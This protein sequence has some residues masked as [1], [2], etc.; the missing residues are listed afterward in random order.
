MTA[1][2]P[3]VP[4]ALLDQLAI[5]GRLV[6]PVGST[7]PFQ[8]LVRVTRRALDDYTQDD[9]EDV[10]FVPLIGEQGWPDRDVGLG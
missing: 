8:H 6:M 9:L 2:G 5:G 10:T 7:D 3:R 1:G 4:P